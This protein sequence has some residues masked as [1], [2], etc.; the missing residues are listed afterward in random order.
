MSGNDTNTKVL[1]HFD[2]TAGSTTI[3]DANVGGSAHTWTASGNSQLDTSQFE[4]GTAACKF[5]G[6]ANGFI[7]TPDSTDWHFGSGD[8][9]VDMW[10]RFNAFS[11]VE[12][13]DFYTL[14][15]ME[16]SNAVANSIILDVKKTA[17]QL[18]FIVAQ[19]GT[20]TIIKA[21]TW[22]P[23]TGTWYHLA[24]VRSGGSLYTFV[25][26][27]QLGTPTAIS[28]AIDTS[29][30]LLVLGCRD[31]IGV[32]DRELNGWIDEFRVSNMARWTANFTPPTAAYTFSPSQTVNVGCTTTTS[33]VKSVG[34][35]V[36]ATCTS[37]TAF[38]KSVGKRV[39]IG[40]TS[41]T[42][43]LKSIG[44]KVT[45]G[46]I[47]AT[48]WTRRIGKTVAVL[49]AST[50]V[51]TRTITRVVTIAVT[52]VTSTAVS[53]RIAKTVLLAS[54]TTTTVTKRVGKAI[55]A[56]CTSTARVIKSVGKIVALSTV[57]A[58]SFAK[59]VGKNVVAVCTSAT[60][61]G[62]AI[63]FTVSVACRSAV[64]IIVDAFIH[65][66]GKAYKLMPWLPQ[67]P[68]DVKPAKPF[69]P[70]WDIRRRQEEAA[71]RKA[72]E[73]PTAVPLP[74]LPVALPL[75]PVAPPSL[76]QFSPA[77]PLGLVQKLTDAKD[78]TDIADALD[79]LASLDLIRR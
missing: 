75:A 7:S 54:T 40:C 42:S 53:K 79:I 41:T 62:K 52:S 1:L 19:G 3:P 4:F 66:A 18:R 49:S 33:F 32:F 11:N 44:K 35:L 10:V 31:N 37:T 46:C 2:G 9:T 60:T 68:Y 13:T 55:V 72:A 14:M 56:G 45:I 30:T 12:S 76:A 22:N 16:S 47:S 27:T 17:Q 36:F 43:F 48:A 77:D 59:A 8:F 67:P 74:P 20:D 6:Q 69:R 65:G 57:T 51:V 39:A 58:V 29:A 15:W 38:L 26:G 21:E 28:G 24:F 64:S 63:G 50:T 71:A 34:K 70:I 73:K 25:N 61:I 23:S 5:D 78:K